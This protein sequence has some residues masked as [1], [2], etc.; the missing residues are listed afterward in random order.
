MIPL[1]ET[2][3]ILEGLEDVR[4]EFVVKDG[5]ATEIVGVYADGTRE[6]SKRTE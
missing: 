1:N 6:P 4:F 2:I 3:F 5:K